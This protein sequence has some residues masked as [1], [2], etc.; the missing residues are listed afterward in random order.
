MRYKGIVAF[1]GLD[2]RVVFQGVHMMMNSDVGQRWLPDE[3]RKS[4]LV[5]IG[6]GL[7]KAKMIAGLER[8]LMQ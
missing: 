5:F 8:C 2:H 7:P 3:A 6:R 1:D 4:K